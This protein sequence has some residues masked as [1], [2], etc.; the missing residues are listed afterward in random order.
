MEE[1]RKAGRLKDVNEIT[2]TVIPGGKNLPTEKTIYNYSKDISLSGTQ[3]QSNVFLPIDT[4]VKMDIN[5]KN[6]Q[7][8][9]TAMGKV[10]WINVIREHEAYDAGVEFINIIPREAIRK[11]A[12]YISLKQKLVL[13]TA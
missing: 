2:I 9:I 3:I 12:G 4:T 8:M 11:L 5:L 1:K 10:K 6:L 7:Q 13:N